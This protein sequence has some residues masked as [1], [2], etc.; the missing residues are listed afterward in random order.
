[1]TIYN[2]LEYTLYMYLVHIYG[3][4]ADTCTRQIS[5]TY[6]YSLHWSRQEIH[7][8]TQTM[9]IAHYSTIGAGLSHV[10]V[11]TVPGIW[12]GIFYSCP[13]S[14]CPARPWAKWSLCSL[15]TPGVVENK[16]NHS[17]TLKAY[18][19]ISTNVHV[20]TV[21]LSTAT[22]RC[23]DALN[24]LTRMSPGSPP[25][26]AIAAP[27]DTA[28]PL[29]AALESL[30]TVT[31]GPAVAVP[32]VAAPAAFWL[33]WCLKSFSSRSWLWMQDWYNVHAHASN[34]CTGS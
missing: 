12:Q 9:C 34:Y 7:E 13:Y 26:V 18:D 17:Y 14:L 11:Y 1:M 25:L 16:V 20:Q 27:L 6:K 24:F 21:Y 15:G 31:M 8:T 32:R 19:Q 2:N 28:S 10:H 33:G 22:T 23:T 5:H 30:L 29:A 4:N 3:A